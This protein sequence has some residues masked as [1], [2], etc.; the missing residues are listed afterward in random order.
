VLRTVSVRTASL[1]DV[2]LKPLRP[3]TT[4][5]V[6]PLLSRRGFF[7]ALCA[8]VALGV[9]VRASY[10]AVWDFPLNDGGLFYAMVTDLQANLYRLPEFTSYNGGRLPYAYPPLGFYL[11]GLLDAA[12]PFSLIDLFRLLPLLY[13]IGTLAAFALIARRLLRVQTAVIAA[14]VAFALIPR[15]YIWLL[16]G[17]GVARGLGLML[18]LFALHEVHRLYTEHDRRFIVSASVLAAGTVLAH[19]ET[20]WFLAFSTVLFWA[21]YGRTRDSF[22]HSVFLA[23][24]AGALTLPWWIAVASQHGLAPFVDA[25]ASGGNVLSSAEFALETALA[26]ARVTATS[27]PFF[28]ILGALGLLGVLAALR[29]KHYALPAWWV[30]II[31]LDMRAYPTFTTIPV[32][33]L[34]GLAISH[35]VLPVSHH[36]WDRPLRQPR[37]EVD[38]LAHPWR[39]MSRGAIAVL[40]GMLLFAAFGAFM[41]AP[42]LGGEAQYLV[43][44]TQDERTAFRWIDANTPPES[45]FLLVPRGPWQVDKESEWFSVIAHRESVTTVQGTEWAP[46][47]E[48]AVDAHDAAWECGYRTVECLQQWPLSSGRTFTHVYIPETHENQCCSTL[49]ESLRR[50]PSYVVAYD[51]AGGTIFVQSIAGALH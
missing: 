29:A 34:A 25:N 43:G 44:L 16:M 5:R 12:T 18:A 39:G 15:S 50:S 33:L 36:I 32:A 46:L 3:A 24:V 14:T 31:L 47:H 1:S 22:V 42:G 10:V 51:G 11:A 4:E 7:L 13:S 28:P 20:G 19:I 41:R 21:A 6:T 17:G 35:I 8:A 9:L 23:I 40:G 37:D 2:D 48:H 38:V 26:I 27:E 49:L 30:A 45:R